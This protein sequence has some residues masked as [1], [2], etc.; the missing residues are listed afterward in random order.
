L[1]FT[2][3]LN[4]TGYESK[5]AEQVFMYEFT[6]GALS[7]LSCE[8]TGEAVNNYGEEGKGGAYLPVS[9]LSTVLPHWMSDDGNRVFFDTVSA[10]VPQ[11]T[12]K[13]TD[14]Y[15]WERDG[16]GTCAQSPGCIYMLSDGTAPEGSFLIGASTSGNDVFITTRS[17]LV[18]EDENENVDVYDVRVGGG[19]SPVAPQCTGAGCQGVPSAPPIFATPPSVTY[20][21]VGNLEPATPA[22]AAKP[23]PL[24]RAQKLAQA[25]R[26]CRKSSKKKR[27]ACEKRA[28]KRYGA[29]SQKNPSSK[30]RGF[31]KQSSGRGK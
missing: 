7:C 16:S 24:T 14:V 23:K 8:P 12:N 15:E 4:L 17:K 13:H 9:R 3:T 10:L 31:V 20:N 26:V 1:L 21:G 19:K 30:K 27:A 6:T 28:R 2:S 11:D 22:P 5:Y 18:P 25:L 29:K